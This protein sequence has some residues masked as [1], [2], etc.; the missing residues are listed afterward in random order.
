VLTEVAGLKG[1]KAA[2]FRDY[3]KRITAAVDEL[4][5]GN[6]DSFKELVNNEIFSG[7]ALHEGM[8][9]E[10][11]EGEVGGKAQRALANYNVGM[12]DQMDLI[13]RAV[14]DMQ[15]KVPAHNFI[16][17]GQTLASLTG[18][19]SEK[20]WLNFAVLGNSLQTS[21]I[22][23]NT[24]EIA[25]AGR[26]MGGAGHMLGAAAGK[27][28]KHILAPIV[29]GVTASVALGSLLG[30]QSYKSSPLDLK[31][32]MV[33]PDIRQAVQEGRALQG[34]DPVV[35]GEMLG[36]GI[37]NMIPGRPIN[38]GLTYVERPNAYQI[39][40]ETSGYL[41]I[42][43]S[44]QYLGGVTRGLGSGNITINDT[45]RPLTPNYIDRLTGEG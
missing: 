28:D 39:R 34:N 16:S 35:S 19:N 37:G 22:S 5:A 15:D 1:K 23:G 27:M 3:P 10:G 4:F 44:M 25:A 29:A 38:T 11:I 26:L 13:V 21:L 41:G 6:A 8:L 12:K 20:M 14:S 17:A 30:I 2:T 45:R 24:D 42:Q 33:S 36:G 18:V 7:S 9:I 40:G 31:G 32:G 43:Q